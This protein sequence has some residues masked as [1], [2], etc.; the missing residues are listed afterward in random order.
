DVEWFA[1]VIERSFFNRPDRS[2]DRSKR[3]HQYDGNRRILAT[4]HLQQRQPIERSLHANITEQ[5]IR[6][7]LG[8]R[9]ERRLAAIRENSAKT[10][11]SKYFAEQLARDCVVVDSQNLRDLTRH[12][13]SPP[14]T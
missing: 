10:L 9:L 14:P 11:A 4:N 13:N 8:H 2:L 1:D 6:W 5:K 12:L 7:L 3:R